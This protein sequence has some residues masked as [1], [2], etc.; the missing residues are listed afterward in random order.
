MIGH[1]L[2]SRQMKCV[3]VGGSRG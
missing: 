3:I 2:H 1:D